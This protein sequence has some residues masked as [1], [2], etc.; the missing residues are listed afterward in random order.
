MTSVN[1]G[2]T[3]REMKENL[4]GFGFAHL[5]KIN[6]YDISGVLNEIKSS[7]VNKTLKKYKY[8]IELYMSNY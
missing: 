3:I 7:G 1:R 2:M 5:M 8:L 4:S 6:G